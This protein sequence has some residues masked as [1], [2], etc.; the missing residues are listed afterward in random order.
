MNRC[1]QLLYAGLLVLIVSGIAGLFLHTRM[2]GNSPENHIDES[3]RKQAAMLT[4]AQDP[5]QQEIDEF[6][7]DIR[8]AFESK[9]CDRLEELSANLLRNEQVFSNGSWKIYQYY[10]AL[11]DRGGNDEDSFLRDLTILQEWQETVPQ[12]VAAKIATAGF[13]VDYAW[14]A[15]GNGYAN[16]VTDKGWSLMRERLAKAKSILESMNTEGISDPYWGSVMLSVALGEGWPKE[17][18]DSLVIYLKERWPTYWNYDWSRSYSLLP[19]WYGEKDDWVAYAK[20]AA[21]Q[22]DGLGDEVYA[23]ITSSMLKFYADVFNE[24]KAS[25]PRVRHGLDSMLEKYPDSLEIASES[26]RLAVLGGD[27]EM[28]KKMFDRLGDFYDESS[29]DCPEQFVNFRT[30]ANT[31]KW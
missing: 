10:H 21:N 31:G 29:W 23:R 25:W 30:W 19:R 20:W 22:P 3:E 1:M 18:Y 14:Y 24:T 6:R 9:D 4:P 2:H 27:Q 28:A 13:L 26:A 7:G 5:V 16:T 12:S 17:D 15:R 11:G 8:S